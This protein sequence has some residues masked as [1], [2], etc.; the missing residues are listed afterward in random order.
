MVK[1]YL[2]SPRLNFFYYLFFNNKFKNTIFEDIRL[3]LSKLTLKELE[4][5]I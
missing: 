5:S 4:Q 2:H 3:Q 1:Y